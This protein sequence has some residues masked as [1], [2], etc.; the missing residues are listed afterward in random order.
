MKLSIVICVYNEVK[1]IQKLLNSVLKVK[2][3]NNFKKE[4]LIFDNNS[5]DGTKEILKSYLNNKDLSIYFNSKN[6]GKGGSIIKSQK[7]INGDYVIFQDADLEYNP[8]NYNLLLEKLIKNNLDAV[9]GSR[10]KLNRNYHIYFLNRIAVS[11]YSTLINFLYNTKFTDTATNHKLIRA[12]IFK[13]MKLSSTSF[14]ID[15]EISLKLGKINAK[16]GE[17]HINY[18]PRKYKDGKKINFMDGINSLVI[19]LSNLFT[20]R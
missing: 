5:D 14:A 11:F 8:E 4:I 9:Y 1:T 20:N 6:I 10:I 16:C 13:K 3:Q 17:I 19:I 18:F 7:F 15:F 12:S 2:L